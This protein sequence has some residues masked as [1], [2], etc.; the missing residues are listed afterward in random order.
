MALRLLRPWLIVLILCL[1]RPWFCAAQEP[2]STASVLARVASYVGDYQRQLIG[3]VAEEHYRQNAFNTA[4][5]G[6]Q[7]RQFRELRSDLLLVKLP[8]EDHWLQFRDVFEVDRKPVRDRDERLHKLFITPTADAR[9][10]AE[11]IQL[12]SSRHNIGPVQ[13]TINMPILA[14]LF[15][16][17]SH[18]HNIQIERLVANNSRRFEPLARAAH[19][20]R[21][22][23]TETG[24][25]TLVRGA[26]GKDIPSHGE[27]WVDSTTGR[28]LQTEF[29][30][31]DGAMLIATIQVTYGTAPGFTLLLPAEMR[32]LYRVGVIQSR[33]DGRASYSKF[34]QFTVTTTEKPKG[35]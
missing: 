23:F 26:G 15:F 8:D 9:A 6:R 16:Q 20:W 31:E 30:S 7:S 34:R 33:I 27:I 3:V 21:L 1:L 25:P 12:E 4:R 19:V 2:P 24:T 14:M 32:E 22:G 17:A 35:Q 28:I 10:Q 29:T 13:R 11:T 5:S 18:R